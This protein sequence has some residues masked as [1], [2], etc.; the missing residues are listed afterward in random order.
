VLLGLEAVLASR[1]PG[2]VIAIG[3]L[4]LALIALVDLATGAVLAL[5]EFFY[6]VPIALVTFARGRKTGAA[7]AGVSAVAFCA[8]EIAS[9]AVRLGS[10]VMYT[11]LITRFLVFELVSLLIAPMRSAL[12][13]QRRLAQR[14]AEAAERLR[15][16]N[17]L[18]DTLL[19]AVSHDLKGPMA[20]IRGSVGVLER[21]D[22]LRLTPEQRREMVDQIAVSARRADALVTDLLD[23]ERLDRGV[24]DPDR[25]PTD[26]LEVARALAAVNERTRDRK[27]ESSGDRVLVAVDR[28]KIER[29][30]DNLLSNAG[31]YTPPSSAIAIEVASVDDG[32]ILSI[33]DR[34][35]GVDDEQKAAIFEPFRRGDDASG[36]GVGIGLSLVAKFAQLHGGAAWVEDRPGG[37][38]R[39]C[40]RLPGPLSAAPGGRSPVVR[41]ADSN[42]G[43]DVS[44]SVRG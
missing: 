22:Q 36:S 21:E 6:F 32:V 43:S 14:E 28:V 31:K 24:L 15:A 42:D 35:P 13:G 17:G 3:L 30:V 25:E 4:L 23:L 41:S 5:P 44:E 38:A 1:S 40:V 10:G 20:A 19:H 27:L 9:H 18:K 2:F 8:S 34:G 33:A 16:L 11:N 29:I 37:G 12:L 26:V 39:F 7:M